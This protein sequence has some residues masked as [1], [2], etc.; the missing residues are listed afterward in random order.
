MQRCDD[1]IALGNFIGEKKIEAGQHCDLR[2]HI[3]GGQM[4]VGRVLNKFQINLVIPKEH[5]YGYISTKAA[6]HIYMGIFIIFLIRG[7][8]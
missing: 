3:G 2:Y 6:I 8:K 7:G 5:T 4:D 1:A